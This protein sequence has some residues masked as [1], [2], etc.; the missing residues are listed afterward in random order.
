MLRT[1]L[2]SI[3][4][5]LQV[6]A[7]VFAM[8]MAFSSARKPAWVILTIA[9]SIML[10]SR[11]SLLALLHESHAAELDPTLRAAQAVIISAL[12]V[13]AL[14]YIRSAFVERERA[15][16][17]VAIGRQRLDMAMN[18]APIGLWYGDLPLA[19]F[20][21]DDRVCEHFWLPPAKKVALETFY[22]R[23]HPDDRDAV[24]DAI[25]QTIDGGKPYDIEYRTVAPDD[26]NKVKWIRAIGR[27]SFEDNKPARF[28]GVTLDVTDR[29]AAEIEREQLLDNERLARRDAEQA[30]RLKDEFLSTVSHE[31][32]TPLNAIFGWAQLLKGG[33]L[34][35]A[36]V[37]EGV[38]VIERN[39]RV[40][41]QIIEDLLDMSRIISGKLR[42]N[43]GR[44]D[45]AQVVQAAVDSVRPAA[46]AREI[47]L[48]KSVDPESAIISGD[49]NRLQQVVWNLL[50][51]AIKFTPKGGRVEVAVKPIDSNMQIIVSDSGEGISPEFLPHIFERFR[52]ADS[53]ASR[54]H[55]GL[56]LG[57]SI[58]RHLVEM[59]GGTVSALSNGLGHGAQFIVTLPIAA[60]LPVAVNMPKE[61]L[62]REMPPLS[63]K[64]I[65]VLVVDDEADS[66]D[67]VR[68]VLE[69]S[70]AQVTTAASGAEALRELE[71][72][73]SDVLISDIGMPGL[74]GYQFIRAVRERGN[75]VP[76][77]ALTAFAR[78]DDRRRAM[79]AGYQLHVAK[80]VDPSELVAIVASLAAR[81]K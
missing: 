16:A 41:T 52:Q 72:R 53:S 35:A 19:G 44:V 26:S 70:E 37:S 12:F 24:R 76:A 61:G 8:R 77:A 25:T 1:V 21:W 9:L 51:N 50:S 28:N 71:H 46:S 79:L 81:A 3:S 17:N 56:G 60:V 59:H 66:R 34:D 75:G 73:S 32:R 40:Q 68:V 69:K 43:I 6:A 36:D 23:L 49:P 11:M 65:R 13:V 58:V 31:L 29:K 55:G 45:L 20:V 39:A 2:L 80:P 15:E 38:A 18:A 74:D 62:P 54:S 33:K 14:Y 30:N 10:L 22:A 57:L 5:V 78:S 64:G 42:L 47:Q 7:I 48:G 27:V 67:L 4:S 63:L